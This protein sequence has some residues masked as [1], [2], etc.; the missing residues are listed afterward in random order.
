MNSGSSAPTAT[1][2]QCVL[3][4]LRRLVQPGV[5]PGVPGHLAAGAA[6]DQQLHPVEAGDRLVGIG[7]E[8]RPPAAARR[9]VGGDDELRARVLDPRAQRVGR[10]AGEDH[11]V[12]RPD[13]RAGEHRV[14]RRRDHR[15]V[16]D[17][18]VALPDPHGQQHV[19][20]LRDLGVQLPIADVLG[21]AR[22]VALPDDRRLVAAGREVPVDAVRRDVE[23][24]VLE[25]LDRHAVVVERRVLDPGVGPDPV[26]PAPVLAPEGVRV[27][28]RV[29]VH[30]RVALG[31]HVGAGDHLG[32]RLMHLVEHC[33]STPFSNGPGPAV[34][35]A[36]RNAARAPRDGIVAPEDTPSHPRRKPDDGRR[37]H[38][39]PARRP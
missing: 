13:P 4:A 26:E 24:A 27:G 31:V 38:T 29:G 9:L 32:G 22:V 28:D 19:G 21:D 18:A 17:D 36:A 6:H 25:P 14:G 35:C 5:A 23:L 34:P 33:V 2:S 30:P 20:E 10:E 3:D 12:H 16:E 7:L 11:R 39:I 37:R 8:R 15:Q 1:G